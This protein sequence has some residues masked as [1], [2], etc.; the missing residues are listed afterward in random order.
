MFIK[1][2]LCLIIVNGFSVV[3]T[4]DE[5]QRWYLSFRTMVNKLK[6]GYLKGQL[7][8]KNLTDKE[9]YNFNNGQWLWKSIKHEAKNQTELNTVSSFCFLEQVLLVLVFVLKFGFKSTSTFT[10]TAGRALHRRLPTPTATFT[11]RTSSFMM[12]DNHSAGTETP[13]TCKKPRNEA[14]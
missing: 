4:A 8:K 12:F 11:R 9:K 7:F 10:P 1:D 14:V 2:K 13:F 3:C 6:L 5:I